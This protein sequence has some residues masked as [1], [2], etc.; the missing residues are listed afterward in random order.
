MSA[1]DGEFRQWFDRLKR[2]AIREDDMPPLYDLLR[3]AHP[4]MDKAPFFRSKSYPGASFGRELLWPLARALQPAS[5]I[6]C[7]AY[8]PP[9]GPPIVFKEVTF[10][11]PIKNL[12]DHTSMP[13]VYIARHPCATV[14]SEIRGQ[15]RVNRIARERR[16]RELL[17][18]HAPAL[19]EQFAEI[20]AGSDIVR[21]V[22]LLWRCEV[23]ICAALVSASAGGLLLTYEQLAT[24]AYSE[25]SRMLKHL[26]LPYTRETESYLD[27]LHR[28]DSGGRA[29][30]RR[31]GWG[32]SYFSVYRNPARERDAW[33]SRISSSD[34]LKIESVVQGSPPIEH[35]ASLGRWW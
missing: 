3:K 9:A 21:R 2:Q 29:A 24:D 14:M 23:E 31:T 7:K 1:V 6:Y 27:E 15:E 22:A 34:R 35:L 11:R 13:I 12:V 4:L 26:G 17:S 16:L 28:E 18:E 19:A 30:P 25:S 33:K 20:V 5:W 32:K 10:I 8:T